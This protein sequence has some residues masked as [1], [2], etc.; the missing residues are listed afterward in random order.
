[1]RL[2]GDSGQ[3]GKAT[4]N[5][6]EGAANTSGEWAIDETTS[7]PAHPLYRVSTKNVVCNADEP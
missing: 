1:M 4:V 3:S 5:G 6:P 2:R 7:A